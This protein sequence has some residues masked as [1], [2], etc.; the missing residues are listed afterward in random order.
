MIAISV[1]VDP[2]TASLL[3][4]ILVWLISVE[5]RLSKLESKIMVL[6]ERLKGEKNA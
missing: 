1:T 5:K 6:Y 3:I 2:L 4:F